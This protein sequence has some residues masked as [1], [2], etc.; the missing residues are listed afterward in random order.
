MRWLVLLLGSCTFN[1]PQLPGARDGCLAFV[2]A[3]DTRLRE[4]GD[5]EV[6]REAETAA[7]RAKCDRTVYA[8]D[9]VYKVCIPAL[10]AVD[11]KELTAAPE[12]CDGLQW[13]P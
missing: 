7:N 9:E 12:K 11:C 4:C 8:T 3:L 6:H 5:S 1:A 10:K 2:E 13:L